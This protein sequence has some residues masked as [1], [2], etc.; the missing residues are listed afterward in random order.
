MEII[1]NWGLGRLSLTIAACVLFAGSAILPD[2]HIFNAAWVAA[3]TRIPEPYRYTVRGIV[4]Q[5]PKAESGQHSVMIR[6]QEIP[7]YV[8]IDGKKV[9]MRAMTMP[10][11]LDQSLDITALK[12]GDEIEFDLISRWVPVAEDRIVAIRNLP[13][14]SVTFE[15]GEK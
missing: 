12:V 2:G 11:T 8:D 6:H 13:S 14:G 9:G 1:G 4:R 7:D 15:A 5:L 10:F 3:E